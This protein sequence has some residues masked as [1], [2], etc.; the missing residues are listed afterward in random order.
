MRQ[1]VSGLG[2][3][4]LMGL[5]QAEYLGALL[6]QRLDHQRFGHADIGTNVMPPIQSAIWCVCCLRP[7]KLVT[8]AAVEALDEGVLLGLAWI[9]VVPGDGVLVGPPQDGS[10]GE[11]GPPPRGN[12]PPDRFLILVDR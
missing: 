9:D 11:L 4:R 5:D 10:T 8:Q 7:K 2:N 1:V 12:D 3:L 6:R